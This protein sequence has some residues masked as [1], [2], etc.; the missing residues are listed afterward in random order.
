M[1]TTR[2][3]APG[4]PVRP[5]RPFLA[6]LLVVWACAAVARVACAAETSGEGSAPLVSFVSE[7]LLLLATIVGSIAALPALIEFLSERK[8]RRER[9]A[10]CLD[11]EPVEGLSPCVAGMDELV[12][13]MADLLDRAGH[14]AAYGD[15]KVGNEVLLIGPVLSGKKALARRMAKNAGLDRLITVY[16]PRNQD[17]L[18]E[19]KSLVG[20]YRRAKVMLL[21]PRLDLVFERGDEELL[22][23]L[24]AL[25]ESTSE[26]PNVLVVG[27][28]VRFEPDGDLDN[29]FGIKLLLPGT[30][31]G[32]VEARP[33]PDDARRMNQEVARFYLQRALAAGFR[34]ADLDAEAF[35]SRVLDSAVNPAEIED[36]VGLCQTTAIFRARKG[37]TRERDLTRASLET[38]VARVIVGG[39]RPKP[40]AR[41]GPE[42][43][44]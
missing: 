19:A 25:I 30:A 28:A 2:D 7:Q 29:L 12:A 1:P 43:T 22:A 34:L 24:D 13:G 35:V 5:P 37:E 33:V 44:D 32:E 40:A 41:R 11:D 26:R 20:S 14:P 6:G 38:A 9:M 39:T 4:G 17:A 3:P 42:S 8:K 31:R 16:N 27:T 18:A 23:E 15:L 10:L 36:V 21:L